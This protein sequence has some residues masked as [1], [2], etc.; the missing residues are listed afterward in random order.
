MLE[1]LDEPLAAYHLFNASRG[2]LLA[3]AGDRDAARASFVTARSLAVN[4]AEQ[5]HLD[6]RIAGV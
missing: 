5:R 3:R 4:P 1:A 6:R 2:E